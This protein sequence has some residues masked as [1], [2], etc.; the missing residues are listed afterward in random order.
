MRN[1]NTHVNQVEVIF[2]QHKIIIISLQRNVS[3]LKGRINNQILGVEVLNSY[4]HDLHR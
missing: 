4:D 3:Q 2:I 1:E